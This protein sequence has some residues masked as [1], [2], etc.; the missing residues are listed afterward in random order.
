MKRHNLSGIGPVFRYT[1]QQHYKTTSVKILLAVL[2]ILAVAA[3]PAAVL[4]TGSKE[5]DS[6][7]IT[8]IYLNN[9]TAF[10]ITAEDI[11]TDSRFAEAELI[12]SETSIDNLR[13]ILWEEEQSAAA[14]IE[15]DETGLTLNIRGYHGEQSKVTGADVSAMNGVLESALRDARLRTLGVT[16]EQADTVK[17][18]VASQVLT[19]SDYRRS[20]AKANVD[21]GTHMMVNLVY[22]YVIMLVSMLAVSYIFQLCIEEKYSK[23]VES[24]LVSVEPTALLIGKLLAVTAF[25]LIGFAVIGI[26]LAISW[27]L[28]GHFGDVSQLRHGI[29][30]A[31]EIDLSALHISFGTLLLFALCVLLAYAMSASFTG[32][33]GSCCSKMEDT[34]QAS[35]FVVLFLMVGYM[36]TAMV[37]ASENDTAMNFMALFPLTSMYAALPAFVCGKIGAGVFALGLLL[38]AVTAF[39]LARLA[40]SVYRMMILYRGEYPKPR[41]VVQMLREARASEKA[42]KERAE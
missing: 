10:E 26:G 15:T 17:A 28:A 36:A 14:V 32:I 8:K 1:V 12:V 11:H 19:V 27:N 30:R 37:P 23:L 24:L 21:L 16:Q 34:Q 22:C 9:K 29:E 25:L 42:R 4:L 18:H 39:L 20:D 31:M 3:F 35:L 13:Q 40:G 5:I 33:V 2:F 6:T 7:N 41:Q 38:Q